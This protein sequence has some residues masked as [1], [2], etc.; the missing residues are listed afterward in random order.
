[1]PSSKRMTP[2]RDQTRIPH[3]TPSVPDLRKG[4]PETPK[5]GLSRKTPARAGGVGALLRQ[6]IMDAT[7]RRLFGAA[8]KDSVLEDKENEAQS[9]TPKKTTGALCSLISRTSHIFVAINLL[10]LATTRSYST[11]EEEARRRVDHA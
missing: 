7:P 11:L 1:M 3:K 5:S 10:N 4:H 9:T 8:A 6:K 2:Q